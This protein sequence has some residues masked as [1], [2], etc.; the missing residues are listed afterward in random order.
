LGE[1]ADLIRGQDLDL[2]ILNEVDFDC[3]WSYGVNQA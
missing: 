3:T 1:I 2:V